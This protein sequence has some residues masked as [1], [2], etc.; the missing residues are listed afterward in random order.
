MR[1][2]QPPASDLAASLVSARQPLKT[3]P[4][5]DVLNIV[6]RVADP[7]TSGLDVAAFN[8]SI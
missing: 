6:R 8:S 2:S 4:A 1:A 5:D 7:Q 3:M